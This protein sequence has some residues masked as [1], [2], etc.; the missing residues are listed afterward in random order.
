MPAPATVVFNNGTTNL[1]FVLVDSIHGVATYQCRIDG[2][3]D[4]AYQLKLTN[5]R[6]ATGRKGSA[7]L[8]IPIARL[9]NGNQI[10][11]DLVREKFLIPIPDTATGA[12]RIEAIAL[13]KAVMA[14]ASVTDF[15]ANSVGV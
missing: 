15:F 2:R 1:T 10:R 11:V 14:N 6:T 9:V 13:A 12:E 4:L 7:E 8:T 5:P 3:P